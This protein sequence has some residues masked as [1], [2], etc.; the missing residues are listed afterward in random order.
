METEQPA[1][2]PID[3]PPARAQASAP[4]EP[5]V[6]VRGLV[7]RF[8]EFEALRGL[9]LTV[10]R[11]SCFGLLGPNG[12]GKTTTVEILEGLQEPSAGSVRVLGRR[13]ERDAGELRERI[14]VALQETQ[15]ADKLTVE[16]VTR[17]FRSFY[18]R[19]RTVE[20]VLRS[21]DLGPKRDARVHQLSGGQR[22][23]L[24]VACA[25]VGEPE[26]LFLDEPTTGLDPQARR[27]LWEVVREYLDQGGTVV[28]TTH[29]MEEAAQMC[30]AIAIVDG[31]RVIA[32]GSPAELVASLGAAQVIEFRLADG[33]NLAPGALES[34]AG[35]QRHEVFDGLHVLRVPDTARALAVLLAELDRR[36]LVLTDLGTHRA[37][38]DDVFL[39]LTGK[40][41]RDS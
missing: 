26:L 9:D 5:A 33:A 8:G 39:H 30:D 12:A 10:A 3:A 23:R 31:G 32:E 13:W 41:L 15:L 4:P 24:A 34:L 27:R 7:K 14:G 29:Y 28:L 18:R 36:G 16:E 22:Q 25:L 21:V 37:T 19:G 17:L 2:T 35:V 38:L 6:E 1:P 11:G 40:A 20:E